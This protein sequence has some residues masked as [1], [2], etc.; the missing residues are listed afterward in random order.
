MQNTRRFTRRPA[1]RRCPP[2]PASQ[3]SRPSTACRSSGSAASRRA[4]TCPPRSAPPGLSGLTSVRPLAR[5]FAPRPTSP[6]R[7][8]ALDFRC[9]FSRSCSRKPQGMSA[10]F[11]LA[12][13]PLLTCSCLTVPPRH[14]RPRGG[15]PR[16][17]HARQ[18]Q[19]GLLQPAG[20]QGPHLHGPRVRGQR[21]DVPAG[22]RR[23][24][25]TRVRAGVLLHDFDVH[26]PRQGAKS[27]CPYAFSPLSLR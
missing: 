17:H 18:R 2:S 7:L 10:S 4:R 14:D 8:L 11:S 13:S 6:P 5:S 20:G 25:P 12:A 15:R 23:V 22:A 3:S 24:V 1:H 19:P 21:Q 27:A 9:S 16:L 26:L